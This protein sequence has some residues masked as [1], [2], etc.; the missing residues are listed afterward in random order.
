MESLLWQLLTA[1][2]VHDLPSTH[3]GQHGLHGEDRQLPVAF[4]AGG[5]TVSSPRQPEGGSDIIT[6]RA[7]PETRATG[8]AFWSDTVAPCWPLQGMQRGTSTGFRTRELN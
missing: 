5:E 6:R 7:P 8:A 3:G 2:L 4:T 1:E